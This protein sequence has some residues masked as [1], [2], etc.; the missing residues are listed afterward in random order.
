MKY[1]IIIFGTMIPLIFFQV[2]YGAGIIASLFSI[3]ISTIT[4]YQL[5]L[6]SDL[7]RYGNWIE[8]IYIVSMDRDNRKLPKLPE[9]IEDVKGLVVFTEFN[10]VIKEK[11]NQEKWLRRS[12]NKNFESGTGEFKKIKVVAIVFRDAHAINETWAEYEERIAYEIKKDRLKRHQALKNKNP[13]W[14]QENGNGQRE[15]GWTDVDY[16]KRNSKR[17]R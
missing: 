8:N 14:Y 2:N 16:S 17:K 5:T 9:A 7:K 3:I 4:V 12:Q 13:D 15:V 6:V 1:L 10:N 11:R